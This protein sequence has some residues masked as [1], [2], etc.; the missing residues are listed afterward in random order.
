MESLLL[1]RGAPIAFLVTSQAA[2]VS[3]QA[4]FDR[5]GVIARNDAN[6]SSPALCELTGSK[7]SQPQRMAGTAGRAAAETL[8]WLH[9]TAEFAK[10]AFCASLHL[11]RA[12][13]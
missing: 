3:G 9:Q 13:A 2:E 11:V 12:A 8:C 6:S 7:T 4:A 1:F 10:G 5:G